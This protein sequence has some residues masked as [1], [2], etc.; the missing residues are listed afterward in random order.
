MWVMLV[1][2]RQWKKSTDWEKNLNTCIIKGL[3]P[4]PKTNP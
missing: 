4:K 1:V 3:Y 2:L